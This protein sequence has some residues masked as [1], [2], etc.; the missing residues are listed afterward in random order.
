MDQL[1][2]TE[3]LP[4]NEIGSTV[5]MSVTHFATHTI[6]IH[7]IHK[8][9]IANPGS[10]LLLLLI[11]KTCCLLRLIDDCELWLRKKFRCPE[12][13]ATSPPSTLLESAPPGQGGVPISAVVSSTTYRLARGV[14][15]IV[16]KI[17]PQITKYQL[18]A[19]NQTGHFCLFTTLG[20]RL[21]NFS[22]KT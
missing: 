18:A 10:R 4:I 9:G 8:H 7:F 5:E 3:Q 17:I 14:N 1:R 6:D 13:T 15:A 11:G 16:M 20:A 2:T 22:P 12:S 19:G 21:R